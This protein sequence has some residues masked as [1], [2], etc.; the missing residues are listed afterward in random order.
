[1]ILKKEI[2]TMCKRCGR[3]L[4]S[5]SAIELGMGKVCWKK[6]KSEHNH[7]KLFE[8]DKHDGIGRKHNRVG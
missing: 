4:K 5:Q 2:Y 8:E 3:K 7:K 1:M 6:Y